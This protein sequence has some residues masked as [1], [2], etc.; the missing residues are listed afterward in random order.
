MY[1]CILYIYT[2]ITHKIFFLTFV[3]EKIMSSCDLFFPQV[4]STFST[5]DCVSFFSNKKNSI[6]NDEHRHERVYEYFLLQKYSYTA[7]TKNIHIQP[8]HV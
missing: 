2:Y 7:L 3:T 6:T 5:F 8:L 4:L 1:I